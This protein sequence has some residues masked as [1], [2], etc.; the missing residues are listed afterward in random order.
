MPSTCYSRVFKDLG[1]FEKLAPR[2]GR[3]VESSQAY[4]TEGV[5]GDFADARRAVVGERKAL[6]LGVRERY[7]L[8]G[9]S[10][11]AN[12]WNRA[13]ALPDEKG[14]ETWEYS[15][16]NSQCPAGDRARALPDEK[17]IE[18]QHYLPFCVCI[19][20]PWARALPDEKGIETPKTGLPENHEATGMGARPPR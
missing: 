13:R 4:K 19:S 17:G 6:F 15:A 9:S 14:I 20:L 5:T 18:T 8:C 1:R 16:G 10:V 12:S 2:R 11:K 3:C 7:N